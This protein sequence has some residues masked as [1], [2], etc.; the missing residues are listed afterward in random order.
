MDVSTIISQIE[1][2]ET[3]VNVLRDTTS[4]KRQLIFNQL[5]E[6]QSRLIDLLAAFDTV[7]SGTDFER[8]LE[9]LLRLDTTIKEL[10][11]KN[12]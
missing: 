12:G 5:L 2:L 6:L 9:Y 11:V 3:C 4:I 10:I 7:A 1:A 8:Y